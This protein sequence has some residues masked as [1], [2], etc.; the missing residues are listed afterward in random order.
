MDEISVGSAAPEFKLPS[1]NGSDIAL[2][3]Y[4]GRKVV[5]LFFIREYN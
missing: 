4:R 3:E 2:S 1:A 5:V